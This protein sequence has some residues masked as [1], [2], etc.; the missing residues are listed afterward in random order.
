MEITA[1]EST[2]HPEA[3]DLLLH[4]G[5]QYSLP[6]A[7]KEYSDWGPSKRV[8]LEGLPLDRLIPGM[9]RGFLW[10]SKVLP[11]IR[12]EGK[13][14]ADLTIDLVARGVLTPEEA[15]AHDLG[16]PWRPAEG[17]L[18]PSDYVPPSIMVVSCAIQLQK[19]DVRRAIIQEFG[20]EWQGAVF[21]VFYLGLPEVVVPE[22]TTEVADA[23]AEKYGD[24][25]RYVSVKYVDE[26]G[27]PIKRRGRQEEED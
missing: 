19:S 15:T 9:S 14:L 6:G 12:A 22:G 23:F 10:H 2:E 24:H 27:D 8:S 4:V 7:I 20:I 1:V 17:K 21:M 13:T 25:V 3:I 26:S 11:L 18:S 16:Q 5:D